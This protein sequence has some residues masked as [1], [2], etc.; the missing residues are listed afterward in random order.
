MAHEDQFQEYVTFHVKASDGSDLE[1]AVID[2]FDFEKAHYVV[3]AEVKDDTVLDEGLY[4]YQ[5]IIHEDGEFD[6]KPIRKAFDYRR[7]AQAY[8]EISAEEEGEEDMEDEEGEET[9]E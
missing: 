8:A 7:I 6:V 3:A 1:M 4:I 2:E 5:A 9:E